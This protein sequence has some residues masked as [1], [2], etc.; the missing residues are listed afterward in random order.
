TD[1]RTRRLPSRTPNGSASF[2]DGNGEGVMSAKE[3]PL[4]AAAIALSASLLAGS[5]GSGSGKGADDTVATPG[6][7]LS[8]GVLDETAPPGGTV[9]MKVRT[10]EVTPIS[11][12]RPRFAF[13]PSMFSTVAG[14]GMF[15]AGEIA[16]AAVVAGTKVDISYASNGAL[17]TEYPIL[18]VA[19]R[20]RPDAVV[21]SSTSFTFDPLSIWSTSTAGAPL[22]ARK[23]SPG[24]V[25]VGGTVAIDDVVPGEGVW[26]AGT[27]VSVTGV[28]FG[29]QTQLQANNVGA[30]AIHAVSATEMQFTL[31]RPTEMRGVRMT[32][33]NPEN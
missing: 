9:Q 26:P 4:T 16:G 20:I 2:D 31:T 17:S 11:G 1:P 8:L 13:V 29:R 14:F 19:L 22:L 28:G 15:A 24:T 5:G 23:V 12:G 7:G 27:V 3:V 18:T 10:T 6:T 21:G 33:Q 32:A 30:T 25:T